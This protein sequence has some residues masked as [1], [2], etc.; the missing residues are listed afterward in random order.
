MR[1]GAN[2]RVNRAAQRLISAAAGRLPRYITVAPGERA[3]AS[4]G[5]LAASRALRT[6]EHHPAHGFGKGRVAD[7]VK[8]HL[9]HRA[10]A[11]IGITSLGHG[12]QR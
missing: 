8:Y 10:L 12:S 11:Q 4:K 1:G 3:I 9:H 6:L 2:R 5:E 7:P